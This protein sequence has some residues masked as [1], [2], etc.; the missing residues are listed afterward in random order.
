MK[1][2]YF[3]KKE[4]NFG[5]DLNN[6][7]W[8][9]LVP[10]A[11]DEDERAVFFGIGTIINDRIYER[12]PNANKIV[13]F[14]SGVGY[15][16]TP[17]QNLP[18]INNKWKIYCLRGPLSAKALG[19][20][21][22]FAVTDGAVLIRRLFKP[23]EE[24]VYKFSY[25]PHVDQATKHGVVWE[26]VCE[27]L[28]YGYIDPRW[29]R[30]K[31]LNSLC[32][33]EIIVT[34]A[35]HGAIVADALRIPWIPIKTSESIFEFKWQDWCKSVGLSY[36]PQTIIE[37]SQRKGIKS[38]AMD[39]FAIKRIT[40][41]MKEIA[42]LS[43]CFLSQDSKIEQVTNKLEERIKDFTK[44]VVSGEFRLKV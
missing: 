7:L 4:G 23:H 21:E 26:K 31:V 25:M 28:G 9:E 1:L 24:K 35:M 18:A 34:E 33:A 44:D 6:W 10:N 43:P 12:T 30:E 20:D 3:Q 5:D 13:V 41:Q 11:F 37:L 32:Q 40:K 27:Q 17:L 39:W 38:R 8:K 22:Q 19:L 15:G 2:Y 36:Q 16:R 14:G 29:S 42:E